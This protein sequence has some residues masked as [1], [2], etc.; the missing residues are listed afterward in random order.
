MDGEP[1]AERELRAARNQS[2]FR[3]VNEKL[4][5]LNRAFEEATHLFVISCECADANCLE[6]L[7][8]ARAAYEDVRSQPNRF[9]VL[10]GH[11]YADVE[12]VVAEADGYAIVEKFSTAADVAAILD[13]RS[14]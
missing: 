3:A 7:E 11:V 1:Q 10:R 8:L 6:T 14:E 9:V 4:L 5:D 2:M 13:P 12:K